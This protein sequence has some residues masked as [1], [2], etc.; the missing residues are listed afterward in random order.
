M[1]NCRIFEVTVKSEG[2]NYKIDVIA[3]CAVEASEYIIKDRLFKDDG[4]YIVSS[5]QK[6]GY[7]IN[8]TDKNITD[9][10]EIESI[11]PS[12]VKILTSSESEHYVYYLRFGRMIPIASKFDKFHEANLLKQVLQNDKK[13]LL[14]YIKKDVTE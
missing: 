1:N 5:S 12:N 11:N 8:A 13:L 10:I 14:E 9:N 2:S 6:T 3:N 7:L 4:K